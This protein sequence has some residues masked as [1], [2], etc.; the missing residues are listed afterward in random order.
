MPG[1]RGR[2]SPRTPSW[3][4][5]PDKQL[6]PWTR[7]GI[8]EDI[9][10]PFDPTVSFLQD[11]LVETME[12]FPSR[13]IH[14]GGDE[15]IKDQWKAVPAIQARIRELGLKERGGTAEL[16]Y[17]QMDGFIAKHGRRLVGWDEILEGGLAPG[18]VVMSWTGEEGGIAAARPATT[19]S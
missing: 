8:C 11:V 3:G 19:W 6:R 4:C 9:F 14:I 18:A 13:F 7:W 16:V 12:L 10:N 1:M 15:A 5:Y 17:P 2:P